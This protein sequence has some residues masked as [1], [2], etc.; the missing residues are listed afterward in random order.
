MASNKL[1]PAS[2]S[3]T[4]RQWKGLTL[5]DIR[6]RRAINHV[7][8]EIEKERLLSQTSQLVGNTTQG[9]MSSSMARKLFSGFSYIDYGVLAFQL[10]KQF[11]RVY[12]LFKR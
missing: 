1:P 10:F 12:R 5:E 2:I 6:Y 9:I 8:M 3:D 7:K 11:Q 4:P